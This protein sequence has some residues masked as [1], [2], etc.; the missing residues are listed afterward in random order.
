[1]KNKKKYNLKKGYVID[2]ISGRK[3]GLIK[4]KRKDTSLHKFENSRDMYWTRLADEFLETDDNN[5]ILDKVF[6]I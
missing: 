4:G 1:M 5:P 6:N 2:E 3:K